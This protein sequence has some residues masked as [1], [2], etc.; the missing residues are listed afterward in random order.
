MPRR[1][2]LIEA[3]LLTDAR[4]C[5]ARTRDSRDGQSHRQILGGW[6]K[7]EEGRAAA[8]GSEIEGDGI[9]VGRGVAV[10]VVEADGEHKDRWG[11]CTVLKLLKHC[12]LNQPL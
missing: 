1:P 9:D 4:L 2:R 3:R 11:D 7:A 5:R 8:Q 10:A 6:R 12:P